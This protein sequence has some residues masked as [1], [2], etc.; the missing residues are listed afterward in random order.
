MIYEFN[1]PSTVSISIYIRKYQSSCYLSYVIFSFSIGF[2]L[3]LF[4]WWWDEEIVRLMVSETPSPNSCSSIRS[5]KAQVTSPTM[6]NHKNLRTVTLTLLLD[7]R[8]SY[9]GSSSLDERYYKEICCYLKHMSSCC[10]C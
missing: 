2:F 8:N 9:G 6:F 7:G 4:Y 3:L 1:Y 5:F 10:L